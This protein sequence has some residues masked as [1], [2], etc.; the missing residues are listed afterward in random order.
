[1]ANKKEKL[2]EVEIIKDELKRV[3]SISAVAESDGGK[4]IISGLVK[5]ILNSIE[6]ISSR[7]QILTLG[8]FIAIGANIDT[9]LEMLKTLKKAGKSKKIALEDLKIALENIE[10]D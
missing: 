6:K 8:E 4:L 2:E 7:Y 3:G 5:D 1:M 10:K 9:K